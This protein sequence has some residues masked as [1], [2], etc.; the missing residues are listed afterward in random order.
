MD[1]LTISLLFKHAKKAL[2]ARSDLIDC[3]SVEMLNPE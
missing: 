1:G 2:I 3:A